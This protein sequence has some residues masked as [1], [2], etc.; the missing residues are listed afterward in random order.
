MRIIWFLAMV[1]EMVFLLKI[2]AVDLFFVHI[3][4]SINNSEACDSKCWQHRL[5][6]KRFSVFIQ[7][8]DFVMDLKKCWVDTGNWCLIF[9]LQVAVCLFA[10]ALL[11]CSLLLTIL[12]L[13]HRWD[14]AN[15][16]CPYY[17][18]GYHNRRAKWRPI[19]CIG[20]NSWWSGIV[21]SIP[22]GLQFWLF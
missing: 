3:F 4:V 13:L 17:W 14:R 10:T 22:T 20:N 7:T 12:S 6:T 16:I 15:I 1:L 18:N 8:S 19:P 21:I 9:D 11:Y 2:C 5:T